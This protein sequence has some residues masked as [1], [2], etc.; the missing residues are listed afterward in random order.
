MVSLGDAGPIDSLVDSYVDHMVSASD[1]G[2]LDEWMQGQYEAIGRGLYDLIWEPLASN[3]TEAN[4]VLIAA[5]GSLN[6]ISFAGL[7]DD[8]GDYLVEEFSTHYLSAGRDLIRLSSEPLVGRGLLALGDPD[9]DAPYSAQSAEESL[10]D[11]ADAVS[12]IHATRNVRP[13]C[14][15]F[16]EIR[17]GR[18]PGTG[19]EVNLVAD[20][21][22][23][24]S[25]EPVTVYL[26]KD[27]SEDV[28]K[29]EAHGKRVV[30]LAAH[31]YYL[32]E[33]HGSE[34]QSESSF[35]NRNA[36]F[37][38][39]NPLLMSGFFL[40]SGNRHGRGADSAGTEDGIVTAKEVS[41]MD[42]HGTALVVLSMCES[43]LGK[44]RRGEGIYGLRRAF[45][46]AG[47]RTVISS[48]WPVGDLATARLL[49]RLFEEEGESLVQTM[50]RMQLER[51]DELRSRNEID[52]PYLWGAFVAQGDW[53]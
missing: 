3:L 4:V 47:A 18:L 42:I 11:W 16:R 6:M 31:G 39:K 27:A 22:R 9:Y 13:D 26:G 53:R 5:D 50:R 10:A 28:F 2:R 34:G 25:D 40:K 36:D 7:I 19:N 49:G 8:D 51:I 43:G 33:I 41:A 52:H 38:G 29:A 44:V 1:Y 17:V 12:R 45:Q 32:A 23:S 35:L 15:E 20:G 46:M 21:W 48:L 14:D 24:F 37:V 30:Y